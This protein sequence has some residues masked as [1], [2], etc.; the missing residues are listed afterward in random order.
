MQWACY[1]NIYFQIDPVNYNEDGILDRIRNERGYTYTDIIAISRDKLPNYE[2]KVR[3]DKIII[4]QSDVLK[5]TKE[6][7]LYSLYYLAVVW[8]YPQSVKIIEDIYIY[9]YSVKL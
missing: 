6:L 1:N 8:L 7:Q 5:D 2:E 3:I 9:N 4:K